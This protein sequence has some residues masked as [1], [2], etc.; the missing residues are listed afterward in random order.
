M[1][2][3]LLAIAIALLA[4]WML[5]LAISS[6]RRA[7]NTATLVSPTAGIQVSLFSLLLFLFAPFSLI[8]LSGPSEL[9]RSSH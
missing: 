4:T 9:G 1:L 2:L 5:S 6:C 8:P 7:P 3:P